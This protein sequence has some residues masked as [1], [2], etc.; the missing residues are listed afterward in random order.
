MQWESE[1]LHHR[2]YSRISTLGQ[3]YFTGAQNY[4]TTEKGG[5]STLSTVNTKGQTRGTGCNRKDFVK[6]LENA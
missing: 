4:Q 2:H 3:L 5:V 1:E 6:C